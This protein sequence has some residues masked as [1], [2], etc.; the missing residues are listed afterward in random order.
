LS[1][2]L[3]QLILLVKMLLE[4]RC[5]ALGELFHLCL[6][7]HKRSYNYTDQCE[8]K[9]ENVIVGYQIEYITLVHVKQN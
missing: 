9:Y 2:Y 8:S 4:N 6:L 3:L 7:K 1:F 5:I